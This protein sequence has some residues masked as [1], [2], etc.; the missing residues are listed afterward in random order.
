[1]KKSALYVLLVF[2]C[3][4]CRE[5]SPEKSE[6]A[7]KPESRT[8]WKEGIIYQ[9][10]PRSFKDTNGDGVGDLA[11]VLEKLDYIESLGVT[12]VWMNP[13]FASP[14]VDNGY[15][16]SDYRAIHPEF[17][18]MDDFDALLRGLHD[19]D[20]KFVLDVVVN[21]SSDQHEWFKQ[22]RSSR[23]N[24]YRDYYHWWPS[25]KGKPTPRFSF[26]DEKGD[27]WK[28][29]SVTDAYYLHYF[30]QEQPDLNW[31]NPKVR[32]E[33]Y[34]IMNFWAEKGV[35]GFRLDAFQYASKDTT[36]PAFPDG[37]EKDII[38]YYGMGP[39][40]HNY[41]KEM[42]REV[43]SKHDVFSVS[44][45]AGSSFEDAHNLVDA[46]RKELH[47]A[48][49]FETVDLV[50]SLE[51][52]DLSEIKR[53]FSAWDKAF[54]EKGWISIF[55]SNHDVARLVSRFGDDSPEFREASSQL[56]NTFLLSMRGTPYIYYG[57]ELGMTN[58][59]FDTISQYRDVAAINGYTKARSEGADMELFMKTLNF[60]SRDNGRTP[61]QWDDSENAGFTTGKPW[62]PVN[63]NY[64]E[65]NVVA[66]DKEP[67]S[68]LNYFRKM[69]SLRKVHPVLVYGDYTLVQPEHP[70]IYAYTREMDGDKMLILLN[71]SQEESVIELKPLDVLNHGKLL[72]NNY[73]SVN[74][75]ETSIMMKP[76]QAIVF[77]L[78]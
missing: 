68:P 63:D 65:I 23:D 44:E 66:Q 33:V 21:H 70:E 58:I 37:Y 3:I 17:G 5:E 1:M 40:L 67:G 20:I 7:M 22:S 11:G 35:D 2:L 48:Y 77:A 27:A 60:L 71:F 38:K 18:T 78:E 13:F 29:D 36:F 43:F 75:E 9:I 10:Y 16:V 57:D 64:T 46:D 19:R 24:P 52:T 39:G 30:A 45:G 26:F 6:T 73:D 76:Y 59:D 12:M 47:M 34:D 14:N 15:D 50:N 61:M 72:I 32:H 8:W 54:A 28:Y 69:A 51:R 4:V 56:L 62:L 31:E 42:H 74:L 49:H 41:L 55:L 25:E 53:V